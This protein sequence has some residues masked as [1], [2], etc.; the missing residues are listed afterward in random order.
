[1]QVFYYSMLPRCAK[2]HLQYVK[3]IQKTLLPKSSNP[4]SLISSSNLYMTRNTLTPIPTPASQHF[5]HSTAKLQFI[6]P[7]SPHS[8]LRATSQALVVCAM[9]AYVQWNYG[10]RGLSASTLSSSIL[11]LLPRVC[12]VS[13]LLTCDSS[14]PSLITALNIPVPSCIGSHAQASHQMTT[15]AC[16]KLS[17]IY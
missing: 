13:M 14:S 5:P 11:T 6:L 4:T 12:T 1:M 15:P 17:R 7:L 8:M 10:G 16:G 3:F 2:L 9:N